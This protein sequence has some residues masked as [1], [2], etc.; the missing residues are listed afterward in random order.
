M[1]AGMLTVLCI[2]RENVR[3]NAW[4]YCESSGGCMTDSLG[5]IPSKGCQLEWESHDPHAMPPDQLAR[6]YKPSVSTTGYVKSKIFPS[7]SCPGH[8]AHPSSLPASPCHG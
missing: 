6:T 7:S 3:C 4:M 1:H 5:V 2:R 8:A